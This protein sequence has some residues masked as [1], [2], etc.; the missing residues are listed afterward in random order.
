MLSAQLVWGGTVQ[1]GAGGVAPPDPGGMGS[2]RLTAPG[3]ASAVA[4]TASSVVLDP[5]SATRYLATADVT[6]LVAASGA[7]TYTAADLQVA[8]GPT[9][10]GGWALQ[11]VYRDPAAPLRMVALS[12]QVVIMRRGGRASVVL[13]GLAAA[14]TARAGTLS[15]AALEGDFGIVPEQVAVN[16]VPVANAGNPPDNPMNGSVTTPGAAPRRS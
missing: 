2:V 5:A 14:P 3:A 16:G 6:A 4:V 8:T 9:A 7:G 11:V 1:P 15:F 12:D 13:S 10:F